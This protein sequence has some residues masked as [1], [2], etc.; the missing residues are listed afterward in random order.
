MAN[1]LP[2]PLKASFAAWLADAGPDEWHQVADQWNW[3]QGSDPLRWIAEQPDCDAA[4]ALVI[5]WRASPDYFWSG[6][7][8]KEEWVASGEYFNADDYDMIRAIL[9]RFRG[10]GY[11]RQEL[12]YDP[13]EDGFASRSDV[14]NSKKHPAL[15]IEPD[16]IVARDGRTPGGLVLDEGVPVSLHN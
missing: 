3:D 9:E 1:Y 4:T 2:E 16:M 6:P 11:S 7:S 15:T 14:E 8:T 13:L 5:F 12:A 10:V